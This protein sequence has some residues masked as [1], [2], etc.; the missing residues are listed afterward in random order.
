M[1]SPSLPGMYET[2]NVSLRSAGPCIA[3]ALLLG[4]TGAFIRPE[5]AQASAFCPNPAKAVHLR[6]KELGDL[7]AKGEGDYNAINRGRAG[8][9][10]GGIQGL[11]GQT[12][13]NYTVGQVMEMQRRR[14]Y[15]VGRYQFIP[16]TLR[17]AVSMSSVSELDMFTPETQDKL[18][19]ALIM[20]KRPSVGAYL[21]GDHDNL[22]WAM[23][24]MAKEW[25][26]IEWRNGRGF[27]DH[28][29]GNRAHI[30]RAELSEVL[31]KVKKDWHS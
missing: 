17:F 1:V 20:Y 21:R 12:F 4:G 31:Q 7:I 19:A 6:L 28:V 9:T 5:P 13:E 30:S 16:K 18:M 8:D 26:S 22:N 25:A 15:A 29:G 2:F 27:Y 11:T 10:P 3:L 14:L 23:N 24:D